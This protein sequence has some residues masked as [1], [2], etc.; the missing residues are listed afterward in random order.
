[1]SWWDRGENIE[2]DLGF[3]RLKGESLW[4]ETGGEASLGSPRGGDSDLFPGRALE[5]VGSPGP[6]VVTILAKYAGGGGQL[7]ESW[8]PGQW[9]LHSSHC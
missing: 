2:R 7:K 8:E 6:C 1:M 9:C 4:T 5:K 3:S